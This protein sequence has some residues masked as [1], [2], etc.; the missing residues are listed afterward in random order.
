MEGEVK[1][2]VISIDQDDKKTTAP[3]GKN[4]LFII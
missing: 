3:N 2:D 1:K 4:Y